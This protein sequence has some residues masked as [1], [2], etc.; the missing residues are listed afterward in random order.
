MEDTVDNQIKA[1]NE[2]NIEDFLDCYSEDIQVYMLESNQKL[3]DGKDQLK[4]TMLGS[5]ESNPNAET[6]VESRITQNNIVIDVETV[7]GHIENKI[8]RAIAIYEI[9]DNKISKLWF[10]SRTV[11][12]VNQ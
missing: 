4:A 8:I 3:T 7:L 2:Q 11:E 10:G 12:D 1:Y 5:F 6:L 9:T